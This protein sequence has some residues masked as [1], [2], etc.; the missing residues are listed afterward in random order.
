MNCCP[1]CHEQCEANQITSTKCNHDFC[2]ICLDNWLVNHDSCPMCREVIKDNTLLNEPVI[3]DDN[4]VYFN[5]SNVGSGRFIDPN[6]SFIYIPRSWVEQNLIRNGTFY[7]PMNLTDYTPRYL[8]T[9]D[10][11]SSGNFTNLTNPTWQNF[12][13]HWVSR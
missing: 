11:D 3:E 12:E 9:S 4:N 13:G 2:T 7:I 6:N 10:F 5:F 8:Q 1:I